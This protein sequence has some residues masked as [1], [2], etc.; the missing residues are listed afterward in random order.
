MMTDEQRQL[1]NRMR[2]TPIERVAQQ[3]GMELHRHQTCCPFH[4]D[5]HP[6]LH[7][8]VATNTY[9]CFVC[10]ASG[11][12]IDLVIKVRQC[13]FAEAMHWLADLT[14]QVLPTDLSIGPPKPLPSYPP[15]LEYLESLMKRP[16]LSDEAQR[17]LFDERHYRPE[18]VSWL[19]ISS[20]TSPTACN[21]YGRPFFDAPSLLFAYR[22]YDG[23]VLG[24]Q[25]RAL[26]SNETG[27]ERNDGKPRFRFT[28]N[29]EV[30]IFNLPIINYLE[31]G[32]VLYVAEG[33]TDCIA[34]LSAGLK[35]VAIPSATLLRERDREFFGRLIRCGISLVRMYP[36]QDEPGERL[37][38]QVLAQCTAVGLAAER[39][40]LPQGC[41]DFSDYW[42]KRQTVNLG[43]NET[44]T[45]T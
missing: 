36:D 32:D 14:N 31:A 15:D 41:K 35:A 44:D 34:M 5:K 27:G 24:V 33:V 19:G 18:V 3:L 38:R 43:V 20:I 4:P 28:P 42:R 30:H 22:D 2:Q 8:R 11:N 40:A 45:E 12:P 37:Y 9:K 29:A 6:S 7:F 23:Q 25:S 1:A 16:E 10:S 26:R 39:M 17:F 21:R 13:S